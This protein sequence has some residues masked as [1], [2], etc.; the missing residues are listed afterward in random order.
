MRVAIMAAG[1]VGGYFGARL[2][3]AGHDV[4][5]FAR[6]AHLEAIRRDGLKIESARGDLHL[7][8]VQVTDKATGLAP[9]DVVLFAVKL[10][11]T[12]SAAEIIK[13]IVTGN[14]RVIVVQNGID[15]P[16]IVG[17]IVGK[18]R[19]V[20]GLAQIS[21][22]IKAPGVI[23]HPNPYHSLTFGHWDARE[24]AIV[25]AF[26]EAGKNA[27]VD[28]LVSKKIERDLWVKFILLVTMSSVT[29]VTR[30]PIGATRN[31]PDGKKMIQSIVAEVAAVGRARGVD[32]DDGAVERGQAVVLGVPETTRASMSFDL[33]R[34]NRL[35]LDW[36]AGRIVSLGR[37]LN[38]P[39]P[40]C[41]TIYAVLK[42]YR[43]GPPNRPG[44]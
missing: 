8:D 27:G 24:D 26:A 19:V 18:D 9:V 4:V 31:D 43:M 40:V 10:W 15:G 2:A 36:L 44:N 5:F 30:L 37:E 11:D 14:T 25:A 35:E 17:S 38:V 28:F 39:T 34:G 23:E 41:E 12:E 7:K 29:S 22:T 21:A 42:P 13:P 20:P 1:A 33:E 32:L 6:G 3:Q 16:D